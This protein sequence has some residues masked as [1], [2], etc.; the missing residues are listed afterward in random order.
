[1]PAVLNVCS[2]GLLLNAG[3]VCVLGDAS[4]CVRQ[5][6]KEVTE[7]SNIPLG[8]RTDRTGNG[9]VR[10]TRVYFINNSHS[11]INE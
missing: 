3:R 9:S 10:F 11:T 8:L 6:M 1:M 4:D 2:K 7:M 5:Y